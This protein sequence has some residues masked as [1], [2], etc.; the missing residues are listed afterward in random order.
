MITILTTGRHGRTI[1]SFP[2]YSYQE[3][4]NQLFMNFRQVIE[5]KS[6]QELSKLKRES[7]YNIV[8]VE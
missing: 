5:E 1:I 4:L 8:M 6:S 3:N 2:E 7:M